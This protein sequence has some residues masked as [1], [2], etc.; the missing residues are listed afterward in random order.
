MAK[1]VVIQPSFRQESR[2]GDVVFES[3]SEKSGPRATMSIVAEELYNESTDHTKFQAKSPKQRKNAL[4]GEKTAQELQKEGGFPYVFEEVQSPS[5]VY[6]N[7]HDRRA[8]EKQ[9]QP[10]K[11]RGGDNKDPLKSSEFQTMHYGKTEEKVKKVLRYG[12]E[13]EA[14]VKFIMKSRGLD[15]SSAIA[16][17]RLLDRKKEEIAE[18]RARKV[19]NNSKLELE[20]QQHEVLGRPFQVQS[21]EDVAQYTLDHP[22]LLKDPVLLQLLN[23][24]EDNVG[25]Q[26]EI[27]EYCQRNELTYNKLDAM[28]L[29]YDY[30]NRKEVLSGT[31]LIELRQ[32][33]AVLTESGYDI[34]GR[35]WEETEK[36]VGVAHNLW[37]SAFEQKDKLS[38]EKEDT[39]E[40]ILGNTQAGLPIIGNFEGMNDSE[41]YGEIVMDSAHLV[42]RLSEL[43][44]KLVDDS[45]ILTAQDFE[46]AMMFRDEF[47]LTHTELSKKDFIIA[48]LN[49]V[50]ERGSQKP[51]LLKALSIANE[52]TTPVLTEVNDLV[53]AKIRKMANE[54]KL[55]VTEMKQQITEKGSLSDL[56]KQ[57]KIE[58]Y[59]QSF[60]EQYNISMEEAAKT[61][62]DSIA[63]LRALLNF[64]TPTQE[65]LEKP[66]SKQLIETTRSSLQEMFAYYSEIATGMV[67]DPFTAMLADLKQILHIGIEN[68]K[69]EEI[70]S[71]IVELLQTAANEISKNPGPML[72]SGMA[73]ALLIASNKLNKNKLELA[74]VGIDGRQPR[75]KRRDGN[76]KKDVM[77]MTPYDI[78]LIGAGVIGVGIALSRRDNFRVWRAERKPQNRAGL[79]FI[80]SLIEEYEFHSWDFRGIINTLMYVPCPDIA[81]YQAFAVKG[82]ETKTD[83]TVGVQRRWMTDWESIRIPDM[84]AGISGLPYA[85][86][87]EANKLNTLDYKNY[88]IYYPKDIES[89]KKFSHLLVNR[90]PLRGPVFDRRESTTIFYPV[91]D[92]FHKPVFEQ[93]KVG[94][95]TKERQMFFEVRFI[96]PSSLCYIDVLSGKAT[97][98]RSPYVWYID[99][100][101]KLRLRATPGD[102]RT[103]LQR[104]LD[105][106]DPAQPRDRYCRR[107]GLRVNIAWRVQKIS[108]TNPITGAQTTEPKLTI[109]DK[110]PYNMALI[111]ENGNYLDRSTKFIPNPEYKPLSGLTTCDAT[112]LIQPGS[113]VTIDRNSKYILNTDKTDLSNGIYFRDKETNLP[114]EVLITYKNGFRTVTESYNPT[115]G[116]PNSAILNTVK[117]NGYIINNGFNQS[118]L[119]RATKTINGNNVQI[120]VDKSNRE[121]EVI[122]VNNDIEFYVINKIAGKP[123]QRVELIAGIKKAMVGELINNPRPGT[124]CREAFI[125]YDKGNAKTIISNN[126]LFDPAG[127]DRIPKNSEL[128]TRIDPYRSPKIGKEYIQGSI[129][130]NIM[131]RKLSK[132]MLAEVAVQRSRRLL[133]AYSSAKP[134]SPD[135]AWP[136]PFGFLEKYTVG[137]QGSIN[138]SKKKQQEAIVM[139]SHKIGFFNTL[140]LNQEIIKDFYWIGLLTPGN[141]AELLTPV[142]ATVAAT[143]VT[144]GDRYWRVLKSRTAQGKQKNLEETMWNPKKWNY[145]LLGINLGSP[146]RLFMGNDILTWRNILVGPSLLLYSMY[147]IS[148]GVDG[149]N[150]NRWDVLN[151]GKWVHESAAGKSFETF[152]SYP[153]NLVKFGYDH[154]QEVTDKPAYDKRKKE[155]SQKAAKNENDTKGAAILEQIEKAKKQNVDNKKEA[156]VKA[157]TN[158][159]QTSITRNNATNDPN[160]TKNITNDYVLKQF[161]LPTNG[162]SPAQLQAAGYMPVIGSNSQVLYTYAG[163]Q[164]TDDQVRKA[165]Q[166]TSSSQD[167]INKLLKKRKDDEV[168]L[169]RKILDNPPLLEAANRF[170]PLEDLLKSLQ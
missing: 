170:S 60:I 27:I 112:E 90:D 115:I 33:E 26:Q 162:F 105:K 121:I 160:K 127:S 62:N 158:D 78:G 34:A 122:R 41:I 154:S 107:T 145:K 42:R 88:N 86:S 37:A 45:T 135:P 118:A 50:L 20:Q 63:E 16:E 114:V 65:N 165:L 101:T 72:L 25:V 35:Q 99:D 77:R 130:L 44:N 58:W 14:D 166:A 55:T 151:I 125:D 163:V 129:I 73:T 80:E 119:K 66:E 94:R 29:A 148:G 95:E 2:K 32:M 138:E 96:D 40:N 83:Q 136:Y 100:V 36:M 143:L 23:Q 134:G 120:L 131:V 123:D 116:I 47:A 51:S 39:T 89:R 17:V 68:V 142:L 92:R 104:V 128:T 108:V 168:E 7:R 49:E 149:K 98:E 10:E 59:N 169:G 31:E 38:Y 157:I 57:V 146:I 64:T 85:L 28:K 140:A 11:I 93:Y 97:N 139:N 52:A 156:E 9:G 126:I 54:Q 133:D 141:A 152:V 13:F 53:E 91:L 6:P 79:D 76:I 24:T 43:H 5:P 87:S 147:M 61:A 70:T 132:K 150:K 106:N 137:D 113:K 167:T 12:S 84:R 4:A 164:M 1:T 3:D 30:M 22:L 117:F 18:L 124:P 67:D 155:E 109:D 111:D 153:V 46:N 103:D 159:I 144:I 75:F 19:E 81:D 82:V 161:K 71:S 110:D 69:P 102:E 56:Q 74:H 8:A 48:Y 21:I 15:R